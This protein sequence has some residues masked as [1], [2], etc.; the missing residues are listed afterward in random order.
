MEEAFKAAAPEAYAAWQAKV[1]A[2]K[3]ADKAECKAAKAADK[4]ECKAATLA[5][6]RYETEVLFPWMEVLWNATPRTWKAWLWQCRYG[7]DVRFLKATPDLIAN[8]KS[9]RDIPVGTPMRIWRDDECHPFM[10]GPATKRLG[11]HVQTDTEDVEYR[12]VI[13]HQAY[14]DADRAR[15][16]ILA[17]FMP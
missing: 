11:F 15:W 17:L 5:A 1:A 12:G 8:I 7:M 16:D 13:I 10:F 4:A 2:A 6:M 9:F 3:A 14:T